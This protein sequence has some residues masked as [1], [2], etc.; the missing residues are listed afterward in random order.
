VPQAAGLG[1]APADWHHEPVGQIPRVSV[2]ANSEGAFTLSGLGRRPYLLW[3]HRRDG[4]GSA[5]TP[6]DTTAGDVDGVRIV[7]QDLVDLTLRRPWSEDAIHTVT[8]LDAAGRALW[9]A[10]LPGSEST[11]GYPPGAYTFVVDGASRTATVTLADTAKELT[12]PSP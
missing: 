4:R 2:S 5:L 1:F 9:R 10:A 7:V 11:L 3:V 12:L 6:V 8:M